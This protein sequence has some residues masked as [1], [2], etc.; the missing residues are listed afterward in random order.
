M[1]RFGAGLLVAALSCVMAAGAARAEE[2]YPT[3]PIRLVVGFPPGGPTDVIG[4]V[5]GQNLS[6]QL[7]KAVVIENTGGAGGVIAATNVAK[8]APDGYTLLVSVE[9]SQTRAKALYPKVAYDQVESFTFL[10]KIAKQRSLVL[11]NPD[12]KIASVPELIA[13]AKSNPGTLN[14]GGTLATTSHIGGTVFNKLNDTRM[15]F[16]SY[17][18]GNQPM[19]DLMTGTL[20]VGFFTEATVAELVKAGKL[21]PL[22]V[23]ANE[24][25]PAFPEL[26][27]ME[28]A[29]ARPMDVSP[30]FGI[31]GPAGMPAAVTTRLLSAIDAMLAN[32]DFT[33]QIAFLGA[34]PIRNST[35]Q[36]FRAEVGN[37]IEYWTEWAKDNKPQ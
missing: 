23:V 34:E 6:K 33:A 4:R 20:Q 12:L 29:G 5:I 7:G 11:V 19:T 1:K 26:P 13:F 8:A 3:R 9:S 27:T 37:E 28:E 10:R 24:R 15:T 22:A 14:F 21:R 16:V 36:S 31:V 18:G 35:P 32:P 2:E 17:A 30:W 25:S